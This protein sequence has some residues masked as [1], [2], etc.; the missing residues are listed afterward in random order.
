MSKIHHTH[1]DPSHAVVK[2]GDA[3]KYTGPD[4]ITRRS[5]RGFATADIVDGKTVH[6]QPAFD[7][8]PRHGKAKGGPVAVAFGQH[9]VG[10]DGT[11]QTGV[12]R[13][14]SAAALRGGKLPTDPPVVGKVFAVPGVT[15]GLEAHANDSET[16]HFD[17]KISD[18]VMGEATISGS[19][20]LPA[21]TSENT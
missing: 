7:I 5:T 1:G 10:E 20:R 11:L 9:H 14:E 2:S 12:S 3:H 17:P 15:R 16:G 21:S 19:T 8:Q 4:Q 6:A 13:T 18:R